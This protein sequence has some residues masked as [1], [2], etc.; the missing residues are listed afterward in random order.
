MFLLMKNKSSMKV[1][2]HMICV[3][4]NMIKD[5]K[6][7]ELSYMLPKYTLGQM[8]SNK[9][10]MFLSNNIQLRNFI[11]MS[12]TNSMHICVL[13]WK[14]HGGHDMNG[15][16][17]CVVKYNNITNFDSFGNVWYK[18]TKRNFEKVKPLRLMT[19]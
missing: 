15:N 10:L 8:S 4:Y 2:L 14:N 12:K 13:L 19:Y 9:L 11:T 3:D 7:V 18:T 16:Q 6:A 17:K 5:M 1:F